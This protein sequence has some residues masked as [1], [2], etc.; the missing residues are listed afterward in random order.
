M[1]LSGENQELSLVGF[2]PISYFGCK[3]GCKGKKQKTNRR[4]SHPLLNQKL[5]RFC[6]SFELWFVIT[7]DIDHEKNLYLYLKVMLKREIFEHR[8]I[9]MTFMPHAIVCQLNF[10]EKQFC[11]QCPSFTSKIHVIQ[12][13]NW[14]MNI[15]IIQYN[16][17][18][19][20]LS[21]VQFMY[22]WQDPILLYNSFEPCWLSRSVW[23]KKCGNR[24]CTVKL[25]KIF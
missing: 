9:T 3:T 19:Q 16:Y 23:P 4:Y 15:L 22:H 8:N 18:W 5:K 11:K 13:C 14:P 20:I 17:T 1:S 6:L 24:P 7:K 2:P 21:F 25:F 12:M 10:I